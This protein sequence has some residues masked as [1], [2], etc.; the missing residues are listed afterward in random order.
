MR[1]DA[2]QSGGAGGAA[3]LSPGD[4]RLADVQLLTIDMLARAL[5]L[6]VA[7]VRRRVASGDLPEPTLRIGGR[8]LRWRLRDVRAFLDGRPVGSRV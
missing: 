1:R 2:R 7:T 8:V 3:V 5:C 6:S 4:P